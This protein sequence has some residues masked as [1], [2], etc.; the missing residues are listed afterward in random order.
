MSGRI[1]RVGLAR[2][3]TAAAATALLILGGAATAR[4][5]TADDAPTL[6]YAVDLNDRAD[7]QFHV[8][9]AVSGLGPDNAILQFAST[10]PG[11]YQVMDIGR[12]VSELHAFTSD[13]T[14]IGVEQ[15][16]TNQW[17][18]ED[19]A[20]V[21][22]IRYSI[23]ETWDTPVDEHPV[24]PM[25]GTSIEDDHVLIN[26]H[27]V[28]P[29]PAGM[30][31]A[32]I[33]LRLEYPAEWAIG[34]PLDAN[35]EGAYLA[36]DY[37][38]FVDSPIL[39]GRLSYAS[40]T[41]TGVPVEIYTY[42]VT[43][44]IQS[45]QLLE[46]MD[47]ILQASGEFLG[48]LPVDR[49]TFLFHFEGQNPMAGAWEHSYS[50]EY[51]LPEGN[52]SERYG[53]MISDIAAHEFFHVVTP[54]HIHSEIIENFDFETPVP[55]EHVWLYE[56]VTEWASDA[57]QLRAGLKDPDRYLAD[58]VQ[59]IRSDE[60][61]FDQDYSLSKLALTSYTAE[62]QAQYPNIY[63]R[64]AIVGSLL[65]L[66][67]LKLS[68]GEYGLQELLLELAEGYGASRPFPEDE[69]FDI[70]T[71]MTYPEIGEFLEAYVRG[72]EP[73]PIDEYYGWIGIELERREDGRAVRFSVNPEPSPEQKALRDAWVSN[74]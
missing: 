28:F 35:A 3:S 40:T 15:V 64:G 59:K 61:F 52:L 29:F 38:H 44:R 43:D 17:R 71:E 72:T 25:A 74:P 69:F 33:E 70:V 36:D 60:G 7:D 16:S 50:S 2:I 42:S 68:G 63:Q 13:G 30:Q 32:P 27:A 21:S 48:E 22:E 5:Q 34:T 55:S 66:R 24:Y 41:V 54:L 9:M 62:G 37:D 47:L 49:Y 73:L 18:L 67:L 6:S 19:P 14:E 8:R 23:A 65:D 4:G 57:M 56:G 1:R 12:Y 53:N 26:A 20:A 10:A 39:L 45:E 31:D 58:Q 11:T 51:V 46:A